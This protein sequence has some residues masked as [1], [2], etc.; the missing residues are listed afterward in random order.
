MPADVAQE[1]DVGELVEPLGVVDHDRVGRPVAEGEEA[2]EGRLDRGA[3]FAAMSASV[4]SLRASSLKP[5]GSPTLVVP[6]PISDDRLVAGLL[7]AAQQHDLH[8]A[9]DMQRRRGRIEADIAR[10]DRNLAASAS[11]AAASVVWWI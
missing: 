2:V 11:S 7:E 6:P 8:E 5:E 10:H 9:A 1:R 3:L 4:S